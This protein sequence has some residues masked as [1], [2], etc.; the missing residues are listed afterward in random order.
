M[1]EI[2]GY[3]QYKGLTAQQHVD[4]F[5]IFKKFL[6]QIKPKRILEIGTAGGGFTLFL[7]DSLD[8][9]GLEHTSIK[10]YDINNQKWYDSL[11][12]KNIDILIENIFD[13]SHEKLKETSKIISYIQKRGVTLVLCDGGYKIGEFRALAPYI[14]KGD[15]IMAHDYSPNEEYFNFNIKNKYW[16]WLEIQDSDIIDIVNDCNLEPF[17]QEYFNN[18]AWVC[19]IKR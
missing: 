4:T 18:V 9:I 6:L 12:E 5:E 17:L 11:K 19:K 8:E 10:T 14:K 13:D 16:N 3:T 2:T 1:D 7:R 15:Y